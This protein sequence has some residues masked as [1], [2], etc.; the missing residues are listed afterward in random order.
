MR[1]QSNSIINLSTEKYFLDMIWSLISNFGVKK[2]TKYFLDTIELSDY[3]IF[4]N[5]STCMI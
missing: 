4:Q 3:E 5:Q 2:S 1:V